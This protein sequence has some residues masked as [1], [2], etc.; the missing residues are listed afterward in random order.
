M[1]KESK[2]KI[3]R[4]TYVILRKFTGKEPL[5]KLLQRLILEKQ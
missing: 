1:I 2:Q 4:A 5:E 3:G